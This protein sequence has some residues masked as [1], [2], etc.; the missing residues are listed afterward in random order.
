M[1]FSSHLLF[2]WRH[3]KVRKY[4]NYWPIS[5]R[6]EKPPGLFL[7]YSESYSSLASDAELVPFQE[8]S[9]LKCFLGRF[10]WPV[11]TDFQ[12]FRRF[13]FCFLCFL[14]SVFQG[15]FYVLY[16]FFYFSFSFLLF[17]ICSFM[18]AFQHFFGF[19]LSAFLYWFILCVIF[20]QKNSTHVYFFI[21]IIH[22]LYTSWIF[23]T[24]SQFFVCIRKI[25]VYMFN[26]SK[27]MIIIF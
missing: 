22:F 4:L 21:H 5:G 12:T 9:L 24:L 6:P 26:I 1:F 17:I 25:S 10:Y 18:F 15:F 7:A 20:S 8:A 19:Q 11:W 2:F 27:Y 14:L 16:S 13:L 3:Q 23:Y